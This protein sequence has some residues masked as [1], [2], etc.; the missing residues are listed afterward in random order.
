M[1]GHESPAQM[2][3]Y[4]PRAY[5]RGDRSQAYKNCPYVH[6]CT[7]WGII[8]KRQTSWELLKQQTKLWIDFSA[9]CVD[10][11]TIMYIEENL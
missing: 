3:I 7:S 1:E 9:V 6:Y 10:Q 4:D 8:K 2:Q 5:V 11:K